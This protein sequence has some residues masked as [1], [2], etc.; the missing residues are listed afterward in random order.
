MSKYPQLLSHFLDY[1]RINTRSDEHADRIPSTQSQV[2]FALN[3]L[4][5]TM[6]F[7]GLEDVHY[8]DNGF[9][10]FF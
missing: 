9:S 1:V 7:I 8:L 3:V 10:Q 5:P 2:D 4:K 6:E